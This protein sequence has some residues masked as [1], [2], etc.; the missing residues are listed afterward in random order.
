MKENT[1]TGGSRK[2]TDTVS[3]PGHV[4]TNDPGVLYNLWSGNHAG[5]KIPGPVPYI[6][7]N[8]GGVN[9]DLRTTTAESKHV[10]EAEK[11]QLTL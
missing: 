4:H 10:L 9:K 5:Y 6:S 3:I 7:T 1:R 8:S 11:A 2:P